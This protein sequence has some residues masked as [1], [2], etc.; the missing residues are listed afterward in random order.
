MRGLPT[1]HVGA[2]QSASIDR[3]ELEAGSGDLQ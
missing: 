1:L 2:T 3:Q